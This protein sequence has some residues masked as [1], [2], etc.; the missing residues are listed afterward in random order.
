MLA[1]N[2]FILVL[3]VGAVLAALSFSLQYLQLVPTN[4]VSE[5]VSRGKSRKR[6]NPVIHTEAPEPDPI[7][8]AYLYC[9]F[10]N[11]TEHTWEGHSLADYK[12]LSVQVMIRHGDRYPLYS[13][14]QTKR[15]AIDC[16]LSPNRVPSHPLLASFISHMALGAQGHWDTSLASL[17]RIPNNRVCEMGELTQTGVVQHLKNGAILHQ[18]YIRQHKLLPADWSSRHVWVETTGKSRTL[19]SGLALLYGFLPGFAWPRLALRQQWSTLFCSAACD[20]PARNRYLD[21]EQKR[22]YRQRVADTEL[23]RTYVAMATALGVATRTLRA[24][25]PVDALLCHVC[26]GLPFPCARAPAP[27]PA[28][29]LPPERACLTRHHFAA[30]RRQQRDDERLRLQAG[31]YR[32]YATLAAH[33]Y[34]NRT[35]QRMERAAR[36]RQGGAEPAFVLASAHD[37]TLQP[38]LSAL[39][40]EGAGFP[41]FAARLVFELWKSPQA[42]ETGRGVRVRQVKGARGSVEDAFVRV[43]Y[44]GEDLTF[45]T[46]FCRHHD[47]HSARPLCPLGNFLSFVRRGMF[48][49]VNATSYQQACHQS[50]L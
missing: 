13:I 10:P 24:A 22:Q 20:C 9:N 11:Q 31:L 45:H 26:H 44:N 35:A 43:L 48:S 2:R 18:A 23:E 7:R 15:P 17:P 25:N 41:R 3:V 5:E 38:V 8:E 33:P 6:L 16:T 36:G 30:L 14:P 39:G 12:L 27:V 28:Q 19:Q 46:A 49:I 29:A 42:G 32:R 50:I 21:Q 1:R 37:V 40:L 4:P 47:R 34:L